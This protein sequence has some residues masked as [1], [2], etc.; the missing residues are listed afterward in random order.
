MTNFREEFRNKALTY[1]G[2]ALGLVAA[3]A[4]NDAISEFIK[5]F[6]PV[7]VDSLW[8]KFAYAI[9][10]TIVVVILLV[11]LERFSAPKNREK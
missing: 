2:G 7:S 1:I 11:N 10:I 3:L 5:Y 8:I 6:F 4:W 9:C